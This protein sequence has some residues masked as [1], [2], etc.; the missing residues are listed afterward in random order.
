MA[1]CI[2]PMIWK[3]FYFK[4]AV[5]KKNP[6]ALFGSKKLFLK[7]KRAGGYELIPDNMGG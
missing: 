5:L 2:F 7:P 4:E 6:P 3:R 1:I